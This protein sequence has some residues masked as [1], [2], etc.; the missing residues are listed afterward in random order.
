MTRRALILALVSLS[1]S[2][3]P[4]LALAAQR[5]SFR[6]EDGVTIAATWY[7]PPSRGPAVILVHMLQRSRR[8]FEAL[9]VRLSS[10]GIGALAIDLRGHGESQG[11]YGESF[12]PMVADIKAARRFLATRSD[13]SGRIGMLGAS[14]GANLVAMAAGD[15]P[16]VVSVALLSPSLEYRG[17]R[18]DPAMRKIGSRPVLMV[19]SSE[20]HGAA[21]DARTVQ[22]IALFLSASLS[23]TK[24]ATAVADVKH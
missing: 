3:V 14:L 24:T 21:A 6:T 22:Q 11:S 13:V 15:D 20:S 19:D 16:S 12:A 5:V 10:E 9:A 2:A 23:E 17:L 7:E 8:D 1:A 18:I 4:R